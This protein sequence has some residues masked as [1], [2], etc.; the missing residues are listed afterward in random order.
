MVD[1]KGQDLR[2]K[3]WIKAAE[4][5]QRGIYMYHYE[6]LFPWQV[7]QKTKVYRDEKPDSCGGIVDWA[8]NNYFRLGNPYRVHDLYQWPG[9][10]E[11]Y[12]GSHPP[13][14]VQMMDDVRCGRVQAALRPIQDVEKLF[15]SWWYPAG[16]FGLKLMEPIDRMWGWFK[17]QLIRVSHIP[18]KVQ[19]FVARVKLDD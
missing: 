1:D 8:Q 12:Y 15:H 11:R 14:V 2:S 9:W 3:N 6:L 13:A 5:E 17:L 16:V 10:L 7:E 18:S 4:L 19:A